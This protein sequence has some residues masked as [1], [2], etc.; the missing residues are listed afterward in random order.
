MPP[1]PRPRAT[2]QR[3]HFFLCVLAAWGV[4]V[5]LGSLQPETTLK[6]ARRLLVQ[7]CYESPA[8]GYVTVGGFTRASKD[9]GHLSS[10]Y[11]A[12]QRQQLWPRGLCGGSTSWCSVVSPGAASWGFVCW[13]LSTCDIMDQTINTEP[14]DGV[15][16]RVLSATPLNPSVEYRLTMAA[17][18]GILRLYFEHGLVQRL[19]RPFQQQYKL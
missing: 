11:G 6:I 3:Q 14:R 4:C 5:D 12:L 16:C 18:R 10:R 7:S 17:S 19:L 15:T 8:L 9:W 2:T 1:I 13:P